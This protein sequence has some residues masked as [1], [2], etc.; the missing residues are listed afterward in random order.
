[1]LVVEAGVDGNG[2]DRSVF[3]WRGRVLTEAGLG[4]G[5]SLNK[6]PNIVLSYQP[7]TEKY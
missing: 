3:P 4:I 7:G 1:V 2:D 5:R 6:A